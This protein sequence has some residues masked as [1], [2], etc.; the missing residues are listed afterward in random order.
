MI[1]DYPL[2]RIRADF[3]ALQR[4]IDGRVPAYLDG[5]GGTQ[6][7]RQ[8]IDVVAD[9][10][11]H[12]NANTGGAFATSRE[13]DAMLA[14]AREAM[15]DLLNASSPNEVVFGANMTS[16]T[17]AVSRALGREWGA[18]DELVVTE[19]D[20]QANI[21]PW[22]QLAEDRGMVVRTLPLDPDTRTL[23]LDRLEELLS[24]RT[25]LL[26]IGAASNALGTVTDVQRAAALARAAGAL[27]YVDAVHFAPHFAVDVRAWDC[28][29]VAC[30]A[31]KF[32]GPHVG[33]LW[34]R[35]TLLEEVRPYKVPPSP[36][37]IPYRW[38]TG[39]LNHEGIA[40]AAAA[41]DWIATLG[42]DPSS[43]HSRRERLARAWE[44]I[45]AHEAAL[46]RMLLDGL[47]EVSGVRVFGPPP[48][49]PRTPT[50][51][52][53]LGG[54][55]PGEIA[56]RLAREGI[57]VWSGHFY[58]PNVVERLGLGTSGGVMR[59]GISAYTGPD[60]IERLLAGIRRITA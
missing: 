15:A 60:E 10:L 23:E 49:W 6:V 43:G 4:R 45:G 47:A 52:F 22:R 58:A 25:R 33:A 41:V 53:T 35:A 20:H 55:A 29:F 14:A 44:R 50:V 36:D 7:P 1:F 12:H 26:A 46:L 42:T 37:E 17:Y 8:V 16:L 32:F 5:P 24:P 48:G 19:L 38:E 59:V 31:Y 28:D 56:E 54:A 57:F 27:S 39:T 11:A 2:E 40:G 30:S 21:A 13:S 3:P 34:G 9:Y 18:G 51:A